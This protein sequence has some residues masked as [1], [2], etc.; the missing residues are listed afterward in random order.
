MPFK[1][2]NLV[3]LRESLCL[4]EGSFWRRIRAPGGPLDGR[5]VEGW[6]EHRTRVLLDGPQLGGLGGPGR[7][8]I[9]PVVTV[10]P[11]TLGGGLRA[12]LDGTEQSCR[13]TLLL[14][15]R[16]HGD[17][18]RLRVTS[19]FLLC[20]ASRLPQTGSDSDPTTPTHFG[21]EECCQ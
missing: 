17:K 5:A 11:S 15:H 14:T 12:V 6:E 2:E 19:Y 4:G 13:L 1:E 18:E 9:V 8:V 16:L 20:L 10:L 3:L 7:S 21:G